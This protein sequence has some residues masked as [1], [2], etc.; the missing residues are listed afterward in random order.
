MTQRRELSAE[1][2][3]A[4]R[5]GLVIPAH[6]LA[7][8]SSRQLDERRQRAL[9]RYYLASG[10][11][12]VAVGVHTT[13]FEIRDKEVGLLEPVLRMAA[14]EVDRAQPTRPFLKVAGVCGP[15]EQALAEAELAALLGYDA[16]LLSMGGLKDWSEEELLRRTEAVAAVIPVIG[17]YL[18]PS[19]GGRIFSFDFWRKFAEIPGIVAIKIAP[20]NRYQTIDVIRAVCY[21]SRRDEIA[22][23]TGNDDNIVNDLLSVYRFQVDGATVEKRI[24]GGLL[25]H[26][27]VWTQKAVELLEEIKRART[28]SSIDATWLTRNIE[29]TDTNA[30]FFDPAHAFAGCIAGIH[31][32]L[33]RQGLLEGTWCLNPEETMSPGQPEEIDRMYRDYPHLHDDAFVRAHLAEWLR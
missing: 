11:G 12:G 23:Y 33:R 28:E 1:K 31:E 16:G 29:V 9:T 4:L 22:L 26:W 7:L 6:P 2:L 32:V 13:Q 8:N 20:F 27:A 10:A 17:F 24:V 14:E 25:G 18:Q 19:V 5:E 15:T 30:A 3:Q 21:S